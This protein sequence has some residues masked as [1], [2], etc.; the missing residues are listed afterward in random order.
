MEGHKIEFFSGL[1]SLPFRHACPGLVSGKG[2]S[3]ADDHNKLYQE[4]PSG[5]ILKLSAR[6][7][8]TFSLNLYNKKKIGK[9][10]SSMPSGRKS[11]NKKALYILSI[12]VGFGWWESEDIQGRKT[13]VTLP[14]RACEN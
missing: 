6:W 7:I 3:P 12:W 5:A 4:S 10:R 11:K 2:G 1:S 14:N 13:S 8:L 9:S